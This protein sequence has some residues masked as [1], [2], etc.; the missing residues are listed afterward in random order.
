MN[1]ERGGQAQLA[2]HRTRN[3]EAL[4]SSPR[5][6]FP[7]SLVVEHVLGKDEAVGS[8]PTRGSAPILDCA[9][10]S[11][12]SMVNLKRQRGRGFIGPRLKG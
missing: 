8:N 6:T 5:F 12:S 7:G 9:H 2:E 1:P 3:A 4:G 10:P 11:D